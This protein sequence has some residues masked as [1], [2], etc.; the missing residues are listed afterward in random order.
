MGVYP[1]NRP[2]CGYNDRMLSDLSLGDVVQLRKPHPCGSQEW[3][4]VRL[5]ADIG[6]QCWGCGHRI[7][8]ERRN[9][10]KRM[11]TILSRGDHDPS[12]DGSKT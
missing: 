5:G 8:L 2:G 9:L 3:E 1:K 4:V 10:A 6:I 12:A 11:K 7:L